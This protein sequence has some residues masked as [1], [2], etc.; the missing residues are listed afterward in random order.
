MK[1]MELAFFC[2][3][4]IAV[5]LAVSLLAPRGEQ[6]AFFF[7][8]MAALWLIPIGVG[9]W[10]FA[11][12]WIAYH[13]FMKRRLVRY[14]KAKMHE[15]GFPPSTAYIDYMSYLSHVID[16]GDEKA[17]RKAS[18]FVGELTSL[19]EMRP[20]TMGIAGPSALETAM[21]EYRP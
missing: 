5:S 7:F 9:V 8:V 15:S 20:L 2:V 16:E 3:L 17:K 12:F 6:V 14:F 4:D 21:E 10:S 18:Y 19:R 11:K 13:L 1:W